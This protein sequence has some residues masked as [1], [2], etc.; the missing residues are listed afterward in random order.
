MDFPGS[1]VP[2]P[3]IGIC[4][5][6]L[7]LGVVVLYKIFGLQVEFLEVKNC[8]GVVGTRVGDLFELFQDWREIFL[9]GFYF[10]FLGLGDS[11][12]PLSKRRL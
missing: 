1:A 5:L 12:Y 6:F 11:K 7:A 10:S 4:N 3:V 8:N 2:F 9:F